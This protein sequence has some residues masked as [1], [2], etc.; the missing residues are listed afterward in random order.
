MAGFIFIFTFGLL[1]RLLPTGWLGHSVSKAFPL[2]KSLVFLP[3][4]ELVISR[5]KEGRKV[6]THSMAGRQKRNRKRTNSTLHSFK[7]VVL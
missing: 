2:L 6:T 7:A 4:S 5:H 3:G 1:Y